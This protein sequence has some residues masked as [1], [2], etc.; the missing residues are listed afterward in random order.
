[1]WTIYSERYSESVAAEHAEA[2]R[3]AKGVRTKV[4]KSTRTIHQP[5][6]QPPPTEAAAWRL[7]Q[8]HAMLELADAKKRYKSPG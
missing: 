2:L 1:M 6:E 3:W 7:K 4:V 5:A 8:A